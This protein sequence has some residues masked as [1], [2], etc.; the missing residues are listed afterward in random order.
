MFPTSPHKRLFCIFLYKVVASRQE[1][2]AFYWRPVGKM[3]G[4]WGGGGGGG[5]TW[6]NGSNYKFLKGTLNYR[7]S[8]SDADDWLA[9]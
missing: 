5:P 2:G 9:F 1:M 3:D 8:D 4:E 7:S 6:S